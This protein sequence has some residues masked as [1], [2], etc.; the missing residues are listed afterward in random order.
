MSNVTNFFVDTFRK[1]RGLIRIRFRSDRD[2]L[3]R[4]MDISGIELTPGNPDFC[5]GNGEMG[6]ECCCDE[7]DYFLRCFPE[8]TL[9]NEE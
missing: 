4:V 7:C 1:I 6:Y 9:E 2:T 5:L 3:E 8:Y